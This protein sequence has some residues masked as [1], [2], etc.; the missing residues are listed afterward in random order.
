MPQGPLWQEALSLWQARFHEN[1]TDD[2]QIGSG[3]LTGQINHPISRHRILD[4]TAIPVERSERHPQD[5]LRKS[6]DLL[7]LFLVRGV[8]LRV[9]TDLSRPKSLRL[10][11]NGDPCVVNRPVPLNLESTLRSDLDDE[12]DHPKEATVITRLD[13]RD[14]IHLIVLQNMGV[15]RNNDIQERRTIGS[16]G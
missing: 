11:N 12:L 6:V 7:L 14:T 9:W 8:N 10:G 13:D 15:T 3:D 1:G 16:T 5:T 2:R 4:A